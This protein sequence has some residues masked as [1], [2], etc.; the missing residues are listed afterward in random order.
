MTEHTDD[1][2]RRDREAPQTLRLKQI[3]PSITASDLQKS[4]HWYR[5]VVGFHLEDTYEEDGVLKGVA[6]VAGTQRVYL[7]QDDGAKGERMKGQG[8]RLYFVAS[9]D[10][11]G[12]ADAIRARGG[13][14]ASEPEDMPWGARSFNLVDPDGF[15][16]TIT[17]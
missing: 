11:D 15:L 13:T 7:S 10:V 17:S 4:L 1:G 16:I 3:V 9:Q 14:L 6:L 8:L 2:E 12:V 5:D